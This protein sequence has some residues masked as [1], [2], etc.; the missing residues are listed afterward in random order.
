MKTQWSLLPQSRQSIKKSREHNSHNLSFSLPLVPSFSGWKLMIFSPP[1]SW[2]TCSSREK[3]VFLHGFSFPSFLWL[4]EK[5]FWS[6]SDL[7]WISGTL[8]WIF[9]EFGFHLADK[10][11][12]QLFSS[13]SS[14]NLGEKSWNDEENFSSWG[15]A[16]WT[17]SADSQFVC[18]ALRL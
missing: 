9:E 2:A 8:V 16:F 17:L 10:W 3:I 7:S 11:A 6:S 5:E 15:A 12:T 18:T 4:G 1:Y 13:C 14:I